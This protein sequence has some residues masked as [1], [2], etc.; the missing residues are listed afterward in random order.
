MAMASIQSCI[1]YGLNKI[2]TFPNLLIVTFNV[3][4]MMIVLSLES[5]INKSKPH[6]CCMFVNH[7]WEGFPKELY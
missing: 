2:S 1:D 6:T 4:I 7:G 5:P 3:K